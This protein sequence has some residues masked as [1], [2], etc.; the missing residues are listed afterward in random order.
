[1]PDIRPAEIAGKVAR[2]VGL[3]TAMAGSGI[4]LESTAFWVGAVITLVGMA[5][6]VWGLA[7]TWLQ[8]PV[9]MGEQKS[10]PAATARPTESNL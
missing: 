10:P 4:I 1:V 5:A 8:E 6:F 9:T 7:E 2:G 3:F